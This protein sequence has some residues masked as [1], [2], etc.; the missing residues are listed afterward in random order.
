MPGKVNPV[1]AEALIMVCAQVVGLDTANTCGGLGSYF[2]LNLM[3]PLLAYNALQAAELLTNAINAF[4]QRCV[5][6]ITVNAERCRTLVE[7][8]LSLATAL[9]P[10]IGY[11]AAVSIAQEAERSD[12]TVKEVALER[13]VLPEGELDEL[14]DPARMTRPGLLEFSSEESPS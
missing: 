14:L 5:R 3:M 8:S 6:G 12:R 11:E 13:Q 10:V 9:A 4:T 2:E 7:R 1:I